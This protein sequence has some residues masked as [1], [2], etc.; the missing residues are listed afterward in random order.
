MNA[1]AI[2]VLDRPPE[3]GEDSA[4]RRQIVEGARQMFLSHGFDAASMADIAK[5]AGVSKGT[6]YVYFKDKEELFRAIVL[7]ECASQA[8]GIFDLDHNDHDVAGVLTR[9]GNAYVSFLC[10]PEKASA[11]RTVIAIADRM[12]SIGQVFYET[13][14]SKGIAKLAAYLK[15]QTEAGVL[16]VDDYEVAASQFMESGHGTLFKP[17]LFNFAPPPS[18]ER[19]KHV[20]D[21]AVRMFM[22]AYGAK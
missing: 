21:I 4:K 11:L 7:L 19:V 8:E 16:T 6:L 9:L 14:P 20:V 1:A 18:P 13:G 2:A 12:P 5:A 3:T 10:R 17:V 22:A 15:A